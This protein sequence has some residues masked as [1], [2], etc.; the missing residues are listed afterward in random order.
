MT[1]DNPRST[2]D[3]EWLIDL[4]KRDG[5]TIDDIQWQQFEA[6]IDSETDFSRI[7]SM[8]RSLEKLVRKVSKRENALESKMIRDMRNHE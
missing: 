6:I 3:N 7:R 5:W 2:D 1:K 8:K 4:A